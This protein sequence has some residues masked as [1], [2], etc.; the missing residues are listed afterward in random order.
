MSYLLWTGSR[1]LAT[2]YLQRIS[3]H[4][5]YGYYRP[6]SHAQK[7]ATLGTFYYYCCFISIMHYDYYNY[8]AD[9]HAQARATLGT[10]R[11]EH[12]GEQHR[13]P[14]GIER[15]LRRT[16]GAMPCAVGKALK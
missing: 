4:P 3:H 16:L 6:D 10:S 1:A 13:K 15:A 7:R 11:W 2:E 5:T 9:P 14:V 8:L 12:G